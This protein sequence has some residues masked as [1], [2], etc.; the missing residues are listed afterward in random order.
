MHT[1]HGRN[2]R[3]NW[4]K[5]WVLAAIYPMDT[6]KLYLFFIIL[7]RHYIFITPAELKARRNGYG[8]GW[9]QFCPHVSFIKKTASTGILRRPCFF[10]L[11]SFFFSNRRQA[12][13]SR[14]N[15]FIF[16]SPFPSPSPHFVPHASTNFSFL[17]R[18]VRLRYH[19]PISYQMVYSLLYAR[20]I[21]TQSMHIYLHYNTFEPGCW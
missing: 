12:R 8:Y 4:V 20:S 3:T 17:I 5:K 9:S 19:D 11:F 15:S 1:H 13:G 7:K 2:E 6:H 21:S 16:Y 10:P 18:I 14:F